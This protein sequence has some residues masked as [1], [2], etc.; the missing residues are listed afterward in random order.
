M[1]LFKLDGKL[2]KRIIMSR[3]YSNVISVDNQVHYFSPNYQKGKQ[4]RIIMKDPEGLFFYD[5][6]MFNVI[7]FR[8]TANEEDE[9]IHT[10][11]KC[12]NSEFPDIQGSFVITHKKLDYR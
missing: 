9:V 11:Q 12:Y 6:I 8:D 5:P 2:G 4:Q 7:L 10:Y 1:Q 3:Q